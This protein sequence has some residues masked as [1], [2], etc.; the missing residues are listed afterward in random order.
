[1]DHCESLRLFRPVIEVRRFRRAGQM[2]V[3]SP[4]VVSW[5]ITSSAERLRARRFHRSPP[6]FS[7]TDAAHKSYN[8]CPRVLDDLGSI[9]SDARSQGHLPV[10]V[11]R[12]VA[13]TNTT[14]QK[15]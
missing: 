10:R 13:H 7:L 4:S 12:L 8:E 1:M 15:C 14:C 3:A 2:W 6:R 5:A 11:S 9:E